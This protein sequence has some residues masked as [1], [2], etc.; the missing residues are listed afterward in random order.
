MTNLFIQTEYSFLTSTCKIKELVI[1][2]KKHNFK[3]LAITDEGNMYGVIKF[4]E[5][6]IKN[7]IKPIIGVRV[8][9]KLANFR[10]SLLLYA[11][12]K[13][14]Y[15]NLLKIVSDLKINNNQL[16]FEYFKNINTD[17]LICVLPSS[18]SLVYNWLLEKDTIP[19][20][21]KHYQMLRE[22]FN[23]VYL[24]ID[25]TTDFEYVN[26]H[27][28]IQNSKLINIS[29]VGLL[30]TTMLEKQDLL[31]NTTLLKIKGTNE[32]VGTYF[33][34]QEEIFNAFKEYPSLLDNIRQIVSRCN[35][36]IDMDK[37]HFPIFDKNIDSKLYLQEL[38]FKGLKKRLE[39]KKNKNINPNSY[40]NRLNY[41]LQ[42]IN[43]MG[44]N[45]YFLIV[46]DYVKFAKKNNIMV[47]PGR[48]SGVSSLVSYS[49]GIIDIDPLEYG[50]IFE[51]FL[52]VERVSMPDIDIDFEDARRDEVISYVSDKYGK[53][54]V[55]NIITFSSYGLK[56]AL[57]DVCSILELSDI[58]KQQI[59]KYID[60]TN[61][62]KVT[63]QVVIDENP[64]LLD[65]MNSYE[66]IYNVVSVVKTIEG[67]PKNKSTHA[68]GIVITLNPLV[69]YVPIEIGSNNITQTQYS[70]EYL[71]K[72]GLLK[73]DFLGLHNLTVIKNCVEMI[74]KDYPSFELPMEFNDFKT[75]ELLSKGFTDGIFQMDKDSM[76]NALMKVKV[77]SFNEIVQLMALN[78]P[79]SIEMIP[80]YIKRKFKEEIVTYLHEDLEQI[81]EETN[82]IIIYQEQILQISR[83]FAGFSYGKADILRRAISKK[84]KDVMESIRNDFISSTIKNGYKKEIAEQIF[85]YIEEF[86]KYGF[87]KSHSVAYSV[88]SY[89]TAYLKANYSAYFI[90]CQ[91]SDNNGSDDV[92]RNYHRELLANR[93]NLY[94]PNIN[95]SENTYTVVNNHVLF[96]LSGI[97]GLGNEIVNKLINNRP[98]NN[99]EE[100]VIKTKEFLKNDEIEKLIYSSSLDCFNLS[101]QAM[102]EAYQKILAREKYA[103][104]KTLNNVDYTL[105]EYS[106]EH[107]LEKEK[108]TIG[109]NIKYNFFYKYQG[110][111]KKKNLRKINQLY[112]SF[113]IVG[114][115]GIITN[116][117]EIKT[118]KNEMM[119]FGTL[120][121]DISEIDIVI[122]PKTYEI[123]NITIGKIVIIYGELQQRNN[124]IKPQLV[125][126][127]IENI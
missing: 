7:D 119:A 5:E 47:G 48:G 66:D 17:N 127:R 24:G 81:L 33:H 96:P 70:G 84:N 71:E 59:I 22:V 86:A 11:E 16:D 92:I 124:E 126:N 52:N 72:L 56:Q 83:K 60:R 116:I 79:G 55:A 65:L 80:T 39:N 87:N 21:F 94:C 36:T 102:I 51:R 14:G 20:A 43:Q 76:K 9:Y 13:N 28:I 8:N 122:F 12:N 77:N 34:T 89:Y 115:M 75:F 26:F 42:V 114:T 44:F 3:E 120:V 46:W 97:K 30:Y 107:L 68:S 103:H 27:K 88:I 32:E 105:D 125:V 10:S 106:Y 109:I 37:Y 90:A 123:S 15:K 58:R 1:A 73:M 98:Y 31:A 4:Y 25:K 6:C 111:Y 101:K 19:Y 53:D 99:F 18:K 63:M 49:L 82:G 61:R 41:E 110:L 78:R 100:F 2:A 64:E 117:H 93:I 121:D 95:Y 69:D 85:A 54:H 112:N 113:N 29:C 62:D 74:K 45:D 23:S 40:L 104:I 108:S 118:R 67:L 50:L 57:N 91:M 38:C 35:V